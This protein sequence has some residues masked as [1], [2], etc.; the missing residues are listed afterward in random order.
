MAAAAA[1][2]APDSAIGE[3]DAPSFAGTSRSLRGAYF[4]RH[5]GG[6]FFDSS[7]SD[8]F[9]EDDESSSGE[10]GPA[11]CRLRGGFGGGT[12]SAGR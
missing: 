1:V 11:V 9:T 5:R 6:G 4:G 8:E 3:D 2:A 7:R 10:P 12:P